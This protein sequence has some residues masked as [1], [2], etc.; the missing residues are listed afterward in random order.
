MKTAAPAPDGLS[1]LPVIL[2]VDDS[3]ENLRV[4]GDLLT[5]HY[6]VRI[7]ASG[8]RALEISVQEPKPDLILLDVMMPEMDGYEVL[9]RLKEEERTR[10]IPVVILSS[11]RQEPDLKR[12]YA[13]GVNSYIVKPV[14]IAQFFKAVGE[15][16]LY[17]VLLNERL[18][19]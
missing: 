4:M 13:L 11:S 1:R 16:G 3:P 19:R 8:R 17:W 14:D 15:V 5:P 2:G 7:A 10:E 12:A 18:E 6:R 9:R